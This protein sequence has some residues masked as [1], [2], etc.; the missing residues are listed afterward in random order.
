MA[1]KNGRTRMEKV[2][3]TVRENPEK[4]FERYPRML[5][6]L[7]P[8]HTAELHSVLSGLSADQR[9]AF[10]EQMV[11]SGQEY[12]EYNYTPI[13]ELGLDDENGD[14]RAASIRLLGFEDS[15]EIG[16][17]L[18]DSAS[19]DPEPK[20]RIAAIDILGQY[21]ME[22]EFGERIPVSP[23]AL[24]ETLDKLI[25]DEDP[26]IRLA[27]MVAYAVSENSRV[28]DMISS[29]FEENQREGLI[30]A[31]NAARISLSGDWNRTVLKHIRHSDEDVSLE[32]IRAA[33]ALQ[34]REALPALYEILSRFDRISTDLLL[35]V[36][37]AIA[38][39]GDEG[40]LDVLEILGEAAVDMDGEITDAID[41]CIDT[42]NMAVEMGPAFEDPD[43]HKKMS[44]KAIVMLNEAIEEAKDKCLS[45]LEEKIPRDLEDDEAFEIEDEDDD[46]ECECGEHHHHHHH[47]HH[48]HENPLEGLDLARFRILDDLAAYEKEADRDEDEEEIWAEFEELDEEDLDADS[49]A[50]FIQKLEKKQSEK[51]R[52]GKKHS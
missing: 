4:V 27:A 35:T 41:D 6:D 36:T 44:E 40:S 39:I 34:L 21:M 10:F 24:N 2:L 38:E 46:E 28:K 16:R 31:L 11:R 14:I 50:D 7:S 13:A 20:V 8:E 23:K 25:D 30:A 5:S 52:K 22:A 49:L 29:C 48:E 45:V 42:L 15:R 33:G 32:A 12:L 19:N 37:N 26:D 47:H 51:N 9:A 18:L 1:N 17:K 43:T 3:Q